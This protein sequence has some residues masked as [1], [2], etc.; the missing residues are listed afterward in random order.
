MGGGS[1]E[2]GAV[3]DG[4]WDGK[5]AADGSLLETDVDI[6]L[7]TVAAPWDAR[8]QDRR[9]EHYHPLP[10]RVLDPPPYCSLKHELKCQA[11]HFIWS[12]DGPKEGLIEGYNDRC[13]TASRDG[14]RLGGPRKAEV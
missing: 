11:I 3:T 4:S 9:I 12:G 6:G 7:V 10:L 13:V 8:Y 14:V 2:R 5:C 1:G